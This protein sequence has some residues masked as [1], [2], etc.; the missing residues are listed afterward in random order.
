[1]GFHNLVNTV[2]FQEAAN[3]FRKNGGFY[4]RAP[5]GSRDYREYWAIQEERCRNGYKVGDLWIPGRYYGYLNF[6]PIMKVPDAIALKA[7]QEARDKHGKIS[8]RTADKIMDFPRFWEIDYEWFRFKHIAWNGGTFMGIKSPG[9][10]HIVCLKT[11]GAGFS[12]KEAWDG[13]YNYNFISGSKSYYFA[14]M[15]EFLTKD[16]ILNKVQPMLD[17][18]NQNIPYWKQNRQKKNT[19]MHEKASYVDETGEERGSLSEIMGVIVDNPNKTRGK[20]GKKVVFEEAGSFP[21]LKKALEV[22]LGS[23]KDGDFYVG[24]ASVFGT[25]GEEGPSIEGLDDMFNNP[26]AWDMLEFPNIWENGAAGTDCGY[27]VPCFRANNAYIDED[28]NVDSKGA[29]TSDDEARE[30]KKKSKD[31]KALDDRK[32]E[33]P[34]TP[35]EALQRLTNNI[36]NIAEIDAQIRRI[37]SNRAIQS[38]IRYGDLVRNSESHDSSNGVEFIVKPQI[39]ANPILKYPHK[40][41]DDLNGCTTIFEKPYRDLNNK[42]P[43]GIY[44]IVFDPFYKEAA[45]DKTSLFAIYVL[46]MNNKIDPSFNE[47]PVA[48]WIGRP[49]KLARCYENLFMLADYYNCN[50]QGEAAGGGQGVI[51]YAKAHKL[52]HKL[53]FEPEMLGPKEVNQSAAAKNRAFLMNMSTDRKNQGLTYLADWLMRMRGVNENGNPILT[54]H[55]IYD[56]GF[57]REL[58]KFGPGNFD[59]ISAMIV[60]MYCFTNN[61]IEMANHKAEQSQFFSNE[62]VLFG[63]GVQE[64]GTTTTY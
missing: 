59:R 3:D 34:R 18:I 56:I 35:S 21:N 5:R 50:V 37:Q 2:Y 11:R 61:E 47:L 49:S 44:Q 23:L 22:S 31:P 43:N 1:M 7:F 39:E 48:S 60:G 6:A 51:D 57:L 16:G 58:R 27:F 52:L 54:L 14:A 32:A 55:R 53:C 64:T 26:A 36:F 45:D 4:T 12:Y 42:V 41:S 30:K 8:K 15:E 38:L 24:Q 62:R 10:K 40:N 19:L 20:R 28:G 13:V 29:I 46:K 17:F 63:G 25:G 33:Y 9:G